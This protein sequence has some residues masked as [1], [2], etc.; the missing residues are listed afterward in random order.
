MAVLKWQGIS[1][2][3]KLFDTMIAHSIVEPEMRHGMDYMAEVYLG[4]APVPIDKLI[5]DPKAEQLNMAD[6]PLEKIAEYAAEDADVTL[7]LRS[8]IEPLLK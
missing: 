4:Y 3:G 7:Q 6:V 5:G 1:V 8:A 2:R